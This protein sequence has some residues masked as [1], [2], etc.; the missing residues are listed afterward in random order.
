MSTMSENM[1]PFTEVFSLWNSQKSHVPKYSKYSKTQDS[2]PIIRN[3]TVMMQ[4]SFIRP[5]FRSS[6][7]TPTQP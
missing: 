1:W 6:P 2:E 5:K 7:I 4:D 3:S